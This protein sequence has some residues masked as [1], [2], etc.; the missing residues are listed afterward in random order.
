[1]NTRRKKLW[2]KHEIQKH[3]GIK[4]NFIPQNPGRT[5]THSPAKPPKIF[6]GVLSRFLGTPG[7][8]SIVGSKLHQE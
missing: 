8:A 6:S 4:Q 5:S 3:T 7:C 1:M 2:E